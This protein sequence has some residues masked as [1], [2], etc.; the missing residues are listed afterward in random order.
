MSLALAKKRKVKKC[1]DL[2]FIPF[3]FL[4]SRRKDV[5]WLLVGI[6]KNWIGWKSSF[7]THKS[8]SLL[9]HLGRANKRIVHKNESDERDLLTTSGDYE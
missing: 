7:F 5:V 8:L 1:E 4:L 9:T 6:A 3:F 2:F